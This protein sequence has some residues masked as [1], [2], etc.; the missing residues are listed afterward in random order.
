MEQLLRTLQETLRGAGYSMTTVRKK[1]FLALLDKEPQTMREITT[2]LPE[3]DRA[4]IYRVIALFEKLHIVAKLQMGWKYKLEL[5]GEFGRHHHHMTCIKC[6]RVQVLEA[7][8][9][10]E[11]EIAKLTNESDF[12]ATSHLLEIRGLCRN[13]KG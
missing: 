10:I 1:V 2:Q 4:S 12:T 7:S 8:R 13:C 6:G 5:T 3:V 9:V 11:D